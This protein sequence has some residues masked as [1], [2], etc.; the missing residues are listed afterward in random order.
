MNEMIW[1]LSKVIA[2][3]DEIEYS[4]LVDYLREYPNPIFE[5]SFWQGV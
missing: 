1:G 3:L 2:L 4:E 5:V